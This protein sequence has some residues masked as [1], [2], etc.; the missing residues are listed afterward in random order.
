Y[1]DALASLHALKTSGNAA[2]LARYARS[3]FSPMKGLD[4]SAIQSPILRDEIRLRD[5]LG[6]TYRYDGRYDE[7]VK[8][9]SETL[10]DARK[11]LGEND[12]EVLTILNNLG[13][14]LQGLG[15]NEEALA[16]FREA[17]AK[18]PAVQGPEDQA[19]LI[20]M[21]NLAEQL[22]KMA[23]FDESEKV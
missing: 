3:G 18:A 21:S 22:R 8:S 17:M 4:R 14:A 16:C 1:L 2:D 13:L 12:P 5:F 20:V 19:T 23:R 7:A 9:L 11:T 10:A 15:R 6:D